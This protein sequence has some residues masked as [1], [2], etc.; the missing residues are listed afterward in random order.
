MTA[1]AEHGRIPRGAP[2][3]GD[4]KPHMKLRSTASTLAPLRPDF[5]NSL[6][7]EPTFSGNRTHAFSSR[8]SSLRS[9]PTTKTLS[10]RSPPRSSLTAHAAPWVESRPRHQELTWVFPIPDRPN[11]TAT[12]RLSYSFRIWLIGAIASTACSGLSSWLERDG[13]RLVQTRSRFTSK[14]LRIAE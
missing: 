9:N 12:V 2:S 1:E 7:Q 8:F 11:P 4:H 6:S 13:W 5:L 10:H 14:E 3:P